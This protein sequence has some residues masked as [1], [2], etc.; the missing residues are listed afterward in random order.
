MKTACFFER[1][2][3]F[4]LGFVAGKTSVLLCWVFFPHYPKKSKKGRDQGRVSA[5]ATIPTHVLRPRWIPTHKRANG[6]LI[7]PTKF[8]R[9]P[10]LPEFAPPGASR[11]SARGLLRGCADLCR[12][13][14]V[15]SSQ[16]RAWGREFVH[17]CCGLL[18][19]L[20]Q[21]GANLDGFGAL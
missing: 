7:T 4:S 6:S 10:N 9:A 18:G 17:V 16:T 12:F 5:T 20:V 15:W 8:Q 13:V 19:P 3:F 11:S 2:S 1:C 14:P 21:V